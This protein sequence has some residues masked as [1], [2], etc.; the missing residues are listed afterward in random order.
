ML[1]KSDYKKDWKNKY[2]WYIDNDIIPID[3]GGGSRGS[4]IVTTDDSVKGFNAEEIVN[5]IE[6]TFNVSIESNVIDEITKNAEKFLIGRDE[7]VGKITLLLK[8]LAEI[9]NIN[10]DSRTEDN[11]EKIHQIYNIL[12]NNIEPLSEDDF[13]QNLEE[14]FPEFYKLEKNSRLFLIT[15]FY[16]H[17]KLVEVDSEDYSPIILQYC[18]VL[19]NEFL[20]KIFIPFFD[21]LDNIFSDSKD[22]IIIDA[23]SNAK[24]KPFAKMLIKNN[25]KFTMG[26]M[27]WILNLI[28]D[29]NGNTIQ[30][31]ELLK[32][33]RE[34]T[35][36]NIEEDFLNKATINKLK[37]FTKEYRNKAA[38]VEKISERKY[39]EFCDE[40][41][42]FINRMLG[43]YI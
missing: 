21:D 5:I 19:E 24:T 16:L 26:T 30:E 12:D 6:K 31:V 42:E 25:C 23:M 9:K 29:K 2:K 8:I 22:D 38:H 37:I 4:L 7:I 3:E 20:H 14:T 41:I 35:L 28:K 36:A 13:I 32:G 15:T 10:D 1:E 17:D 33:F 27:E 40:V 34:K 11:E 18:R 39:D 43:C